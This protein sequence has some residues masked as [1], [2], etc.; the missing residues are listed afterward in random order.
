MEELPA[1]S[2]ERRGAGA[3]EE[4]PARLVRPRRIRAGDGE[5]RAGRGWN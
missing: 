1:R 5:S 3:V 2:E 4:L